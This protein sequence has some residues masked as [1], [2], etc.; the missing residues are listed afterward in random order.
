MVKSSVLIIFVFV[1]LFWLFEGKYHIWLLIEST[2]YVILMQAF[3]MKLYEN[4]NLLLFTNIQM[5]FF[6]K[7][8]YLSIENSD[9]A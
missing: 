3:A 1:N 6:E 8:A 9:L 4:V 7:F 5:K 2:I